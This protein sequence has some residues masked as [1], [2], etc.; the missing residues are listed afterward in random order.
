MGDQALAGGFS[1]IRVGVFSVF[2]DTLYWGAHEPVE[3][4]DMETALFR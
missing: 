4:T 3:M 1:M 2:K